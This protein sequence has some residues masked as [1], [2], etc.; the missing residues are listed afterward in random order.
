MSFPSESDISCQSQQREGCWEIGACPPFSN[1]SSCSE[2][3]SRQSNKPVVYT[4]QFALKGAARNLHLWGLLNNMN[5]YHQHSMH[6]QVLQVKEEDKDRMWVISSALQ[7]LLRTQKMS[8]RQTSCKHVPKQHQ[9][10]RISWKK[11]S[12]TYINKHNR[13]K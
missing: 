3:F 1:Y 9:I 6:H 4:V 8:S 11:I 5:Q 10:V 2:T 13:E 12:C 7:L